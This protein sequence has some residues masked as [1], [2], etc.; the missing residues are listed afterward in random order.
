[1]MVSDFIFIP[2]SVINNSM[3]S[4][5][6]AL[7]SNFPDS[8]HIAEST[9]RVGFF[10]CLPLVVL[11]FGY[12]I[13]LIKHSESTIT[14]SQL[15]F[16]SNPINL[17]LLGSGYL[18]AGF[19]FIKRFKQNILILLGDKFYFLSLFFVLS[20]AFVS[21]FPAKVSVNW[22]HYVGL[23]LTATVATCYFSHRPERFF[24]IF[25]FWAFSVVYLS[26]ILALFFPAI[27]IHHN[28]GRWMGVTSNPNT[29]GSM[30]IIAV[31]ASIAGFLFIRTIKIRMVN[32]MTLLG[33]FICLYK[34]NSVTSIICSL[35]LAGGI[36]L[37][38]SMKNDHRLKIGLKLFFAVL[39]GTLALLLVWTLIPEML[40]VDMAAKGVGR[41]VT[42]TGRTTLWAYGIKAFAQKPIM[43]WGFDANATI[44]STNIMKFGQ[45]H[46]G[47]INLAVAGGISGLFF[48]FMFIVH[49]LSACFKILR[50]D[51]NF[52][53]VYLV[54]ILTIL[55]H[56]M[57]ESSLYSPTNLLWLMFVFALIYLGRI[58][59][60]LM[61]RRKV[62]LAYPLNNDLP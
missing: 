41:D 33:A 1:M 21:A 40:G 23:S 55:L 25:T 6:W 28:Q 31:W 36:P 26:I 16:L 43:G 50:F 9:Q 32:L 46:N 13:A 17:I 15:A 35:F 45:F 39:F 11:L 61:L 49:L 58:K 47:Y 34:S 3:Q 29:L 54:L 20:T 56:N 30:C 22:A 5:S 38:I 57:A 10:Y 2:N 27:G 51:F 37:L 53:S 24:S 62:V 60:I 8:L 44:L 7:R 19:L 12:P 59:K 4:G 42:L 18:L 48:L 14:G 52:G